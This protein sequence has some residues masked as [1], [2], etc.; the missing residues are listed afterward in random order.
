[1]PLLVGMVVIS[2]VALFVRAEFAPIVDPVLLERLGRLYGRLRRLSGRNHRRIA[3]PA[4]ARQARRA[5]SG[6]A[7]GQ[8][9]LDR[10]QRGH[11]RQR[12]DPDAA[13]P[14]TSSAC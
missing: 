9:T 1:M 10:L 6:C 12:V 2:T 5:A 13:A 8:I 4:L 11:R 3:G 7:L 14:A